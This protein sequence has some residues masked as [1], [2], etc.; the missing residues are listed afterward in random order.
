VDSVTCWL[1]GYGALDLGRAAACERQ[2]H[3]GNV[4]TELSSSRIQLG[5]P[6]VAGIAC[7]PKAAIAIENTRLL[8]EDQPPRPW[9]LKCFLKQLATY[10]RNK[11]SDS[12]LKIIVKRAAELLHSPTSGF[13]LL[14]R[15]T[16]RT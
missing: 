15:S 16:S 12:L 5:R 14:R 6:A 9:N 8:E 10:P 13:Y 2:D 11:D 3:W 7:H 4:N 1:F